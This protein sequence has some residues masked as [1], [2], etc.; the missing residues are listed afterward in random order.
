M[1]TAAAPFVVG[2]NLPWLNYG[3]DFGANDW[4]PGGGFASKGVPPDATRLF[5]SLGES[6]VD[7]IRWFLFCDG[8]AGIRFDAGRPVSLDK[9]VFADLDAALSLIERQGLRVMPVLFD[10]H[11]CKPARSVNRVQISGRR[12]VLA[13]AGLRQAL[14][15]TVVAPVLERYAAHP[16]VA[17][18]DIINEPEWVTF[19]VGHLNPF[20]GI[21]RRD[22]RSFVS[23]VAN[24]AHA[25]GAQPVTVGSARARWL[26]LVAGTGLDFYQLHWYDQLEGDAPLTAVTDLALDRP[27]IVGEFPSAGS[28]HTPAGLVD[29]ARR[30]GYGG[31]LVWSLLADDTATSRADAL[32]AFDAARHHRRDEIGDGRADAHPG[33]ETNA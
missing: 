18:W 8:R 14:I 28:R 1:F 15:E 16:A 27:V 12:R 4:Q 6:G 21:S 10:F 20:S 32:L 3:C 2:A 25:L 24:L 19:G 13:R 31:A 11:W 5:D 29:M 9:Y 22:L 26:P 17:A 7:V 33:E 30:A 23:D